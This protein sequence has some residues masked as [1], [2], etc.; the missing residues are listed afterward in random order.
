M[1]TMPY[2]GVLTLG[3]WSFKAWKSVSQNV[4]IIQVEHHIPERGGWIRAWV[5]HPD[6]NLRTYP[7]LPEAIAAIE[8]FAENPQW[9]QCR[10]LAWV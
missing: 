4:F 3:P 6:G 9:S 1:P 2:T 8:Q 10:E 5:V 7:T